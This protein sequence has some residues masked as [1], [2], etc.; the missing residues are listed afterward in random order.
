MGNVELDAA[1]GANTCIVLYCTVITGTASLS[2]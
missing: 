2:R 1:N